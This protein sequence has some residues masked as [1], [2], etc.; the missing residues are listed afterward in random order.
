MVGLV[1][2]KQYSSYNKCSCL[3]APRFITVPQ[4][5]EAFIGMAMNLSCSADGFPAPHITW[6][7]RG[8]LFTSEIVNSTHST[9]TESTIVITNLMLSDRGDYI[10][11][12][13]RMAI[14]MSPNRTAAVVVIAGKIN[15]IQVINS[16]C[17]CN[18]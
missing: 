18:D 4:D 10:C 9:Y 1:Y 15:Y 7:F 14:T 5:V 3:V 8:M 6:Y 12:I 2:N 16:L 17:A 13:D 11:E